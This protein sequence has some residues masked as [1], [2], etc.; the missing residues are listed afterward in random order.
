MEISDH[1]ID[2][3]VCVIKIGFPLK[4]HGM[5]DNVF[6]FY[7]NRSVFPQFELTNMYSKI[8]IERLYSLLKIKAYFHIFLYKTKTL[9][10][11]LYSSCIPFKFFRKNI[12]LSLHHH[13]RCEF[14]HG[15]S[16]RM[17]FQHK[18]FRTI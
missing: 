13:K 4:I 16:Y 11:R 15:N 10:Y 2:R 3:N 9:I 12:L 7:E 18:H 8:N 6:R 14:G 17:D 5:Y 1:L